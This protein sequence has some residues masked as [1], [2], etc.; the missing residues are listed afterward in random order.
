M[1][2]WLARDQGNLP[3]HLRGITANAVCRAASTLAVNKAAGANSYPNTPNSLLQTLFGSGGPPAATLAGEFTAILEGRMTLP[4]EWLIGR[5]VSFYKYKYK[6]DVGDPVM[7]RPITLGQTIRKLFEKV[8]RARLSLWLEETGG[9]PTFRVASAKSGAPP[10]WPL[11]SSERRRRRA[12]HGSLCSMWIKRLTVS[13]GW[14]SMK[15]YRVWGHTPRWICWRETSSED[16][17]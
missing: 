12:M 14:P 9:C 4:K 2:A 16:N 8:V 5:V 1:D 15:A 17:V 11:S 13:T 3:W 7:D 10:R 6:G